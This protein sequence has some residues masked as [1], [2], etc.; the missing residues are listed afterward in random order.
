MNTEPLKRLGLTEADRKVYLTLL[1]KGKASVTEI[2]HDSG[3]HRTNVYN[4]LDKL[5][6]MGL[7]AHFKEN[8]RLV[9]K[10]TNPDNL[11][12]YL[13][14]TQQTVQDIIP[15]LKKIQENKLEKVSVE[16][17][18]GEKG[19]KAAYK[20]ILK[21]KKEVLGF[22]MAGQFRNYFPEFSQQWIR[23]MNFN[24]IKNKYLYIEG[25]VYKDKYFEA[26]TIPKE[27]VTP[28]ATHIYDDKILIAIWNPALVTIIIQSS[29][30]ANSFRKYF[31]IL[32][33]A[34]KE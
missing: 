31:E 14:E 18:H 26:R 23:D 30:V 2:A 10:A 7:T 19:M 24:K 32:W 6:E 8:N 12:N 20:D 22:G 21:A 16:V 3:T 28:V 29:E 5:G 33:K 13:K 9:F 4:I 17:F 11:L 15:D 25:Q 27:L 1:K 34:A